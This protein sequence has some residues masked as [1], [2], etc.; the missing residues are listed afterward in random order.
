MAHAAVP[1]EGIK[2]SSLPYFVGLT[3]FEIAHHRLDVE[4]CSRESREKESS[5]VEQYHL[6]EL[7]K[8]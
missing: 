8:R 4:I 2:V 7:F 3:G 6:M 1:E 5:I